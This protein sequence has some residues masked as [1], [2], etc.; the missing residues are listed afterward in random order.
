[1]VTLRAEDFRNIIKLTPPQVFFKYFVQDFRKKSQFL[2]FCN[3]FFNGSVIRSSRPEVF[4]KKS[5]LRN[6]A[7]FTGKHQCEGLFLYEVRPVTL[8]KKRLWHRC[9]LLKRG[10]GSFRAISRNIINGF[11]SLFLTENF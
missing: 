11:Q 6:F 9:F 10:S 1:M 5:V 7:K 8:L 2:K 4:F 3:S